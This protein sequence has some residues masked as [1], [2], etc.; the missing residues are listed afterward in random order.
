MNYLK[1][2]WI[3]QHADMPV[4]LLSELDDERWET[5]KIEI[6]TDGSKAY[7]SKTEESG[8]SFLGEAPV[9]PLAEIAADPEF[10][11]QEIT[12]D[13]FEAEWSARHAPVGQESIGYTNGLE[14]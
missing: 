10:M 2:R 11:P 4:L 13:E 14:E 12:E 1:V 9:P 6:Y 7:A 5:R 3:H 8:G